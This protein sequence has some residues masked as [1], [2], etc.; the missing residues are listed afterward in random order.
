MP[1]R[2]SPGPASQPIHPVLRPAA[3]LL[4]LRTS[5]AAAVPPMCAAALPIHAQELGDWRGRMDQR[6]EGFRAD[7]TDLQ[8]RLCAGVCVYRRGRCAGCCSGPG[9]VPYR[10]A[11]DPHPHLRRRPAAQ[12][13]APAEPRCPQATLTAD[14]GGLRSELAEVKARI[15]VQLEANG[16]TIATLHARGD[17]TTRQQLEAAA[18]GGGRAAA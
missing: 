1:L 10:P 14:M 6:V 7:L 2:A 12:M 3:G 9:R 5:A 16:E 18:A 8:V 13:P 4:L 17:A 11:R 15:R